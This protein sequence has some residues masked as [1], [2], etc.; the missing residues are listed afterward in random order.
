M[1]KKLSVDP[2]RL[3]DDAPRFDSIGSDLAAVVR[4]LRAALSE[5]G[6]P[7]GNDD[8]G[9]AFAEA[10][11][12]EYKRTMDELN[13]LVEAVRQAGTDLRHLAENFDNQ[14]RAIGRRIR[15]AGD[16]TRS[17]SPSLS[18]SDH[19]ALAHRFGPSATVPVVAHQPAG[20]FVPPTATAPVPPTE[21][22]STRT[23]SADRSPG[24]ASTPARESS[25]PQD[26]YPS[27]Q[28]PLGTDEN[29][30]GRGIEQPSLPGPSA[31]SAARADV[32]L[33]RAPQGVLSSPWTK[34]DVA[35]RRSEPA[36]VA[37]RATTTAASTPWSTAT[38]RAARVSVPDADAPGSPPRIP[39][40][41]VAR[42]DQKTERPTRTPGG[43]GGS[44]ANRLA[45]DLAERHGVRAFGFDTPD[46][47]LE[48]LIEIIAAVDDVLP[49]YPQIPLRAIGIEELGGDEVAVL[50]W[51]S[52]TPPRSSPD[53]PEQSRPTPYIA[54]A[55]RAATDPKQLEHTI[56]AAEHAGLIAP[57][58]AQRPVYSSIVRELGRTLDAVGHF[59]ARAAAHRALLTAYL[60]G[61]S[62]ADK[63]SLQR[64]V[65]GFRAWRSHLS[66]RSFDRGRFRPAAALAEAFTDVQL[67]D[68]RATPPAQVLH[69][70][71]VTTANSATASP[72]ATEN[73]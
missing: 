40:R 38:D 16:P 31:A 63:S 73:Q 14:D 69:Q 52:V 59:R 9:R 26:G 56:T 6:E 60:P 72:I 46:V 12:P 57:G 45:R 39:G 53:S 58:C 67:N 10:Y 65:S 3:L 36:D 50:V 7:W 17:D 28:R 21:Q 34:A 41:P 33:P 61:T 32:V 55:I 20:T 4:K 15:A 62:H 71:L 19:G 25:T 35:E 27:D 66:D 47:A 22:A 1:D 11:V 64:T 2:D 5:E 23:T 54:F 51:D 29:L 44:V 24:S 8:A 42:T 68:A 70:L 18:A 48:V 37:K 49:R 13:L 43:S 30:P